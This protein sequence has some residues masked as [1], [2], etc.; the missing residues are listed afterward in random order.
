MT[1]EH[2]TAADPEQPE[3]R[4]DHPAPHGFGCPV[5][6]SADGLLWYINKHL[7][8]PKGYALAFNR[9]LSAQEA[10]PEAPQFT[11]LYPGH[12]GEEVAFASD[13]D[14]EGRSLADASEA[15]F[16]RAAESLYE[17]SRGWPFIEP[18]EADSANE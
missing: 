14:R 10:T 4:Q 12:D 17:M 16:K 18:E 13:L 11:L 8:H 15:A 2:G 9:N 1:G 5:D 7:F 6:L 3:V